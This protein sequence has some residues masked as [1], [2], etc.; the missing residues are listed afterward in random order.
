M[1]REA[2]HTTS[3]AT[4]HTVKEMASVAVTDRR[5]QQGHRHGKKQDKLQD[6]LPGN[7]SCQGT[8]QQALTESQ[9]RKERR[10]FRCGGQHRI[11]DC[12]LPKEVT[13]KSCGKTGHL[14]RVC[15]SRG[16]G[17]MSTRPTSHNRTIFRSAT[18]ATEPL[19]PHY[20]EPS[21]DDPY[22]QFYA[23]PAS[24]GVTTTTPGCS[25][26]GDTGCFRNLVGMNYRSHMTDLKQVNYTFTMANG[27]RLQ[28]TEE[29]LLSFVFSDDR[30]RYVVLCHLRRPVMCS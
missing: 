22:A 5:N 28:A 30:P 3:T 6:K 21:T 16:S 24:S 29:G 18:A 20:E 12:R 17:Q 10:C 9:L 26:I 2:T 27:A 15:L 7:D 13:C 11:R 1:K 8:G 25:V 23:A 14:A 19:Q 4:R